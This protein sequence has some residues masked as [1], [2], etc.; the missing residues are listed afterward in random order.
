MAKRKAKRVE[1]ECATPAGDIKIRAHRLM[2]DAG[3]PAR[4]VVR[5]FNKIS[6][7]C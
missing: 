1:V 5:R 4:E 3:V 6:R 7:G 2:L